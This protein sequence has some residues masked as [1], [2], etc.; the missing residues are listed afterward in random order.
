M[1][2]QLVDP[3]PKYR[4]L[5]VIQNKVVAQFM[6]CGGLTLERDV[7]SRPEGG[8]NDYVHQLPGNVKYSKVTLKRGLADSGLWNWF[9]QGLYDGHVE[10]RNVTIVLYQPDG[11]EAHRW[12]MLDVYPTRWT[13][14]DLQSDGGQ[15]SVES[16][17]L[18][19][20]DDATPALVQRTSATD[21][22]AAKDEAAALQDSEIDLSA[23]ADQVYALLKQDLTIE[24][25]RL[26]RKWF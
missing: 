1:M 5:V 18:S 23:L 15:V 13:G 26:G 24:R 2:S 16:L 25:D 4:F 3:T 9:K 11:S 14:P 17:E 22:R 10:R 20:G 19:S 7:V 8:V 6:D 21:T 12:D